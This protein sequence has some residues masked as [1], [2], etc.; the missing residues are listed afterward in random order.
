MTF[1]IDN[2]IG[3]FFQKMYDLREHLGDAIR[4]R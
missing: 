2:G 1:S 3:Y 4:F